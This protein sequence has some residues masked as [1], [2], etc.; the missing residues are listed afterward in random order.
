[1]EELALSVRAGPLCRWH[2]AGQRED[3][4]LHIG[5][6]AGAGLGGCKVASPS[7]ATVPLPAYRPS[8]PR[9]AERDHGTWC[10]GL[11][12]GLHAPGRSAWRTQPQLVLLLGLEGW[13]P[14]QVTALQVEW[15]T[16]LDLRGCYPG[17]KLERV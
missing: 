7:R 4:S 2:W 14:H 5:K 17:T 15:H 6:A 9:T 16:G 1:M 13:M 10:W 12:P 3:R 8:R 11:P